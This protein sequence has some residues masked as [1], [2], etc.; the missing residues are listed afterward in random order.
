MP[1]INLISR[2]ELLLTL[3]DLL[4]ALSESNGMYGDTWRQ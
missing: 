3:T 2:S 1:F 4:R